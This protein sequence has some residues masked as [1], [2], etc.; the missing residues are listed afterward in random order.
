MKYI[1]QYNIPQKK[2][3]EIVRMLGNEYSNNDP[4]FKEINSYY[5]HL[6]LEYFNPIQ[7]ESELFFKKQHPRNTPIFVGSFTPFQ[8]LVP[9][10][11]IIHTMSCEFNC[12]LETLKR[13]LEDFKYVTGVEASFVKTNA[14]LK[15]WEDM[16]IYDK[17]RI[18]AAPNDIDM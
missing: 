6:F 15:T 11:T 7:C 9:E 10:L 8:P 14:D 5:K 17:I 16:D 12:D 18:A 1:V 4:L 13:N 2:V 3:N